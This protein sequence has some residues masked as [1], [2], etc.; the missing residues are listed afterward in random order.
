MRPAASGRAA[1]GAR[2]RAGCGYGADTTA[3][4][5]WYKNVRVRP[6]RQG[7]WRTRPLPGAL[8]GGRPRA[9]HVR[10]SDAA[11]PRHGDQR[12]RAGPGPVSLHEPGADGRRH[13]RARGLGAHRQPERAG[14]AG[15]HAASPFPASAGRH[16]RWPG[17]LDAW[18]CAFAAVRH[19]HA[20]AAADDAQS[21]GQTQDTEYCAAH[22]R[23][24]R[25]RRP[26]TGR[27]CS[28]SL[29]ARA[30]TG[31]HPRKRDPICRSRGGGG[32]SLFIQ[33]TGTLRPASHQPAS[34]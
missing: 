25:S 10:V 6:W 26:A 5:S 33:V 22:R 27:R 34:A 1:A 21:D 28:A 23:G 7:R 2:E 24:K 14:N 18:R 20:V 8:A 12:R 16:A 17:F 30:G 11:A 32:A 9:A 13:V 19:G 4:R 29:H 3:S 15:I 31:S